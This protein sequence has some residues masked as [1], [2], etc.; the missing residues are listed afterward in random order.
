M[1]TDIP[2]KVLAR[3]RPAD[4]LALIGDPDA[5]VLST[6]SIELQDI[7]RPVDFVYKLQWGHE[8]YYRHVEFQAERDPQMNE[9]CFIYNTRMIAQY[10]APV[11][12]TIIY[13]FRRR[14]PE[15]PVFRVELRGQEINR[16]QFDC[17]RLWE[18]EAQAALDRELPGLAVL[19]P[20][21]KGSTLKRVEHAARQIEA[22]APAAQQMDLLAIL[23]A[24]AESKYTVKQLER[25]IGR[26]RIM[27]SSIYQWGLE[28]GHTKGL[29]EGH[30]KGLLEGQLAA[31]RKLC[32]ETVRKW[33]PRAGA[34]V[35]AAIED[36]TD[37][38]ALEEVTVNAPDLSAREILRRLKTC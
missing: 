38:A 17:I 23:H 14:Q 19:V 8:V 35:W 18:I 5:E 29:T 9:R 2:C 36:C 22:A 12:T 3:L 13:L 6:E 33:H 20:L 37:L 4:L 34:K 28:E 10:K 15:E 21:M 27:E 32:R 31:T 1:K 24:F 26:E 16:W 7:K 25:I 11:I 30:A